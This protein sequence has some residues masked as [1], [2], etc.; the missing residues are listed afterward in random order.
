[1]NMMVQKQHEEEEERSF[2]GREI[3]EVDF[4]SAAGAGGRSGADDGDVAI[5]ADGVSHAGFMVSTALDLLTAVNDG[6]ED[7]I[8]KGE[9]NDHHQSKTADATTV[10]GELRQAG[11]EN[12]RLRRRLEELTTSYGALYHQLVQAQQ[13]QQHNKQAMAGMQLLDALAASPAS[14]RRLAADGDG[15][16]TDSD[17]GGADEKPAPATLTQLTAPENN[18]GEQAAAA[19]MAPCRKAR[20][21]VRA[22]SEA[23]MYGQKMAKGNPCPRAYYRCTMAS[24]C[25][26]RKQVQRCA[27]DRTILMTTY[28]GTHSHPLPAAAAAMASTT[29]AAA[30]MLLSGPAPLSRAPFFPYPTLSASAPFPS[31]TLDLTNPLAT[32][33]AGL[34]LHRG[35]HKITMYGSAGAGGFQFLPG[36][37]HRAVF[38]PPPAMETMTAAIARDP[39]FTTALAAAISSIMAGG[40]GVALAQAPVQETSTAAPTT[41]PPPLEHV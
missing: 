25:P 5:R 35:P 39:N 19:E 10:E 3:K 1:M 36:S 41:T 34:Q 16:R 33:A 23:P 18:A 9:S 22:R 14:H 6:D 15:D 21:S 8:K 11:E 13:Q 31:I 26:V 37:H 17:G 27:E 12:R 4:F 29:S 28:E 38:P 2:F 7:Q 40:G 24:Q 32:S 30:Q 20:V